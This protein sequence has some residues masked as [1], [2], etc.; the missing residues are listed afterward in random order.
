[1]PR[2]R[3]RKAEVSVMSP[4]RRE[5]LQSQIAQEKAY[6]AGLGKNLPDE[7]LLG[8]TDAAGGLGVSTS[9]IDGRISRMEGAI[10]AGTPAPLSGPAKQKAEK[11][12][13]ALR[14]WLSERL[15]TSREMDLFAR[16]GYEYQRAVHKSKK[17]EVGNPQFA[18]N[19][20][21]YRGLM[22]SIDP[23]NPE[24]SSIERLRKDK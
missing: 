3:P 1:M 6:K 23:G 17:N 4:E 10:A 8:P 11:R 9:K 14:G 12:A 19:A 2:G 16:D 18:K 13:D 22:Q 24:A 15:L 5:Q 21:E 7:G 20:N